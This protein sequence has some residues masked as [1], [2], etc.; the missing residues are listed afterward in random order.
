VTDD[1]EELFRLSSSPP[2]DHLR[3][4]VLETVRAELREVPA[5]RRWRNL[6]ALAAMVVLWIHVTWSAALQVRIDPLATSASEVSQTAEQIRSLL[7]ELSVT[8]SQR[9]ALCAMAGSSRP[10]WSIPS[11]G[12]DR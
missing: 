5:S 2:G 12:L 3:G 1:L 6:A 8:E 11:G 9:M 7:P 10:R 4:R